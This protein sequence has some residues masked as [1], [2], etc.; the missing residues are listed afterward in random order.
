MKLRQHLR[1]LPA[2]HERHILLL[3]ESKVYESRVSCTVAKFFAEVE[4]R[5]DELLTSTW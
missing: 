4:A 2:S 3:L 5:S 1:R